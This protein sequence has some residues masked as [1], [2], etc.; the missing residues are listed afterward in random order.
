M[1]SSSGR[2]SGASSASGASAISVDHLETGRAFKDE[3]DRLEGAAR[4]HT[5][6]LA[7]LGQEPGA[8]PPGPRP[9]HEPQAPAAAGPASEAGSSTSAAPDAGRSPEEQW[10]DA[11]VNYCSLMKTYVNELWEQWQGLAEGQQEAAAAEAGAPEA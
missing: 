1:S 4:V 2:S 11:W 5:A 7:A 3:A 9:P 10:A 8:P 6:N